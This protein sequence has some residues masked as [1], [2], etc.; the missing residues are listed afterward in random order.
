MDSFLESLVKSIV[1]RNTQP[2]QW[3]RIDQKVSQ[4][5]AWQYTDRFWIRHQNII[6]N[7]R[8]NDFA[9]VQL[10]WNLLQG[11]RYCRGSAWAIEFCAGRKTARRFILPDDTIL[12]PSGKDDKETV[13]F[14][15][16]EIRDYIIC[17]HSF[18]LHKLTD[19]QF[20]NVLDKFYLNYIGES[21]ISFTHTMQVRSRDA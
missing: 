18:K 6:K 8:N 21:A 14:Y 11:W 5:I 3:H 12:I 10:E 15:Y 2:D 20:Y 4:A 13:T 19:D 17:Y 1:S 7:W 16:S 9:S